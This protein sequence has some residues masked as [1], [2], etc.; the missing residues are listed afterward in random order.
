MISKQYIKDLEF[1]T[2]EDI[3]NYIVESEINGNITQTKQLIN[4]LNKEQYKK[5]L[6]WL[7]LDNIQIQ[8]A[9]MWRK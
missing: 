1:E 8:K 4:K 5:Y 9:I 6:E 2:I 7:E 3:Y